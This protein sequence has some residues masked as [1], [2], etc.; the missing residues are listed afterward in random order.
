M[1]YEEAIE[2]LTALQL[3]EEDT[4]HILLLDTEFEAELNTALRAVFW[5]TYRWC[6]EY[7][8]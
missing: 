5:K 2:F 1:N 6:L 3:L 7:G 4:I 8:P